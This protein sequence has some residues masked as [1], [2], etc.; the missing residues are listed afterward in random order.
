MARR[1]NQVNQLENIQ[2]TS[3]DISSSKNISAKD[4]FLEYLFPDAIIYGMSYDEFWK[5]DPQLFYSF[6]FSYY[7]K[8]KLE[9]EIS[10]YN[11]WLNGLYTYKAYNVVMYN[12]FKEK[13]AE[14]EMYYNKPIDF[15]ELSMSVEEKTNKALNVKNKWGSL[16]SRMK[17]E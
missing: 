9:R 12:S 15:N 16:K 8:L 4:Y 11:A 2:E 13:G 14:P 17:G 5:K 3:F 7:E 6:R 1:T 10:N